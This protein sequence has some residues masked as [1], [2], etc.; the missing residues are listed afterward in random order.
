MIS[1]LVTARST[2]SN[3][4]GPFRQG[5]PRL[6][7]VH[8]TESPLK[9]GQAAFRMDLLAG[10][11]DA[12]AHYLVD[13][14]TVAGGVDEDLIAWGAGSV[15]PAAIHVEFVGY[16]RYT[17]AEWTTPDGLAML[18]LGG[19]LI[20]DIASR[21]SI[22]LRW[23]R[24][25]E[26]KS[27]WRGN[28]LG[29][30]TTHAQCTTVIGGTTHHDPGAGFPLD[31]LLDYAQGDDDMPTAREI[32][33]TLLDTKIRVNDAA[34]GVNGSVQDYSVRELLARIGR[35]TTLTQDAVRDGRLSK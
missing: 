23:L 11:T 13:P 35:V 12:S 31:L 33:D 29:G 2:G 16:A 9:R 25:T 21:R 26:L 24:D 14:G 15:N 10:R 28:G 20:A 6:I 8:C 5:Q 18:R 34:Q 4:G 19:R 30:L 7:V 1:S 32:A 27:A 22:P 17:R 3:H